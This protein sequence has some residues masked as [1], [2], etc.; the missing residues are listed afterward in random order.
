VSST[1]ICQGRVV[2][3]ADLVWLRAWIEAHG[4]WSRFRLAKELCTLWDWSTP[5]GRLKDFAARTFLRKLMERNLISL[6]PVVTSNQRKQGFAINL[7][8]ELATL[9]SSVS[10]ET[11]LSEL[12]P[13]ELLI[14]EKGS[15]ADSGDSE[16][17]FRRIPNTLSV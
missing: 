8:K 9:P 15:S 16:H 1:F 11:S 14:P 6:P 7:P 5:T 3:D 10:I 2:S 17:S 4:S 12:S 13:L